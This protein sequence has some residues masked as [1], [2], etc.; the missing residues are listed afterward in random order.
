MGVHMS[1]RIATEN[2]EFAMPES[3]IGLAPDSGLGFTFSRLDGSLGIYLGLTGVSL[4]GADAFHAGITT[5]YVPS[6][7]IADLE[8]RLASLPRPVAHDD[9]ND[10]IENVSIDS[11]PPPSMPSEI[12]RAIDR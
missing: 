1:F 8:H 12:C 5:H 6:T 4:K 11:I 2:T 7:R 10:I 3:K 9:V